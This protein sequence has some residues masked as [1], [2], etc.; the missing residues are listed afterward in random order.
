MKLLQQEAVKLPLALRLLVLQQWAIFTGPSAHSDSHRHIRSYIGRILHAIVEVNLQKQR[1]CQH[2][3]EW[4]RI[5][6][7]HN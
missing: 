3:D 5:N 7:I 4:F 1:T 6:K 2:Y